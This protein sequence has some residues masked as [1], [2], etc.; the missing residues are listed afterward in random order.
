M[1]LLFPH[2]FSFSPCFSQL[3]TMGNWC[4]SE[5]PRSRTPSTNLAMAGPGNSL[6]G[7]HDFYTQIW[8]I[9]LL[10]CIALR[11]YDI[12][13]CYHYMYIKM[14]I[15]NICIIYMCVWCILY[16]LCIIYICDTHTHAHTIYI[17]IYI[18]S[19]YI[20]MYI[21][22]YIYMYVHNSID[23]EHLRHVLIRQQSSFEQ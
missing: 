3:L 10:D 22:I 2:V 9:F 5:P 13:L 6:L 18:A 8:V 16:I 15:K 21:Y 7:L 20:Y 14:H 12:H 19:V 1:N 4:F 23:V 11:V 17:D